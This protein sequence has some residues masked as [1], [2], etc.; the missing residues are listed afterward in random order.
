MPCMRMLVSSPTEC[1]CACR[2]PHV[3]VFVCACVRERVHV[4]ACVRAC[5]RA[6]CVCVCVCVC[7]RARAC[8]CILVWDMRQP[9]HQPA[10]Q[11]GNA[12]VIAI[13]LK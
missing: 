6:C 2:F 8:A 12:G 11:L 10:I 9:M 1:S 3:S 7:A 5:M 4:C 13:E